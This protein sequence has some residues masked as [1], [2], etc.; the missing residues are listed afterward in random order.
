MRRHPIHSLEG[1]NVARY[2]W[3]VAARRWLWGIIATALL[4]GS[5]AVCAEENAQLILTL[6]AQPLAESLQQIAER[7]D[8]KIAFY[9]EFTDGLQAPA[10]IGTFTPS[11]A[12]D[13]L[14]ADTSLEYVYVVE[15]TVAVRPRT[16][17]LTER[18]MTMNEDQISN[19]HK[20]SLLRR[21]G[22]IFSGAMIATSGIAASD[23]KKEESEGVIDY[24]EEIVVTAE[25]REK[26]ILEVPITI[27]AFSRRMIDELGMTNEED[28]EQLVPGLQMLDD[29]GIAIRGLW[30][31]NMQAESGDPSV[32]VYVDGVYTVD[33]YGVA[34]NLFDVERIEVARGPQGTLHGRNSI[35]GAIFVHSKRPT[36]EFD[37]VFQGEF[38]DQF[39]QRYNFA[40]GG[41]ISDRF[42]Y[43]ITG[44][45]LS[46]DG[47]QENVGPAKDYGEPD[48]QDINT[49]LRFKT[50]RLDMNLSYKH[51]EDHGSPMAKIYLMD[52]P[53]DNRR[54]YTAW[55]LWEGEMPSTRNCPGSTLSK[56]DTVKPWGNGNED[57]IN[58]CDDPENIIFAN[59]DGIHESDSDRV[60]FTVDYDI[61]SAL[62]L[63]YTFG[64]GATD[65]FE[66]RDADGTGRVGDLEQ[67][68][69][70][71][72]PASVPL[73]DRPPVRDQS[74]ADFYESE[75]YSHE[76]VLSS[77]FD[78]P[79]NFVAGFYHY[80]NETAYNGSKRDETPQ[81]RYESFAPYDLIDGDAA[82]ASID[83]R[84]DGHWRNQ[85][86]DWQLSEDGE[87]IPGSWLP[88][89]A[90]GVENSDGEIIRPWNTTRFWG[91]FDIEP[92]A[93]PTSC[94]SMVDSMQRMYETSPG[95]WVYGNMLQT[96][97]GGAVTTHDRWNDTGQLF[98]SCDTDDFPYTQTY[99]GASD[100]KTTALFVH[101]DYELNDQWAVTAGLR[102][103]DDEKS[104][105]YGNRNLISVFGVPLVRGRLGSLIV[106]DQNDGAIWSASV[107]YTPA[108]TDTLIYGRVSNGQRLGG[109][110]GVGKDQFGEQETVGGK[111][112][113]EEL[114]NYELG[115]KGM[116]LD[117]QLMLT[118]AVFYNDYKTMHFM[119]WQLKPE[120]EIEPWDAQPYGAFMGNVDDNKI[121]GFEL[122]G[123][124][125]FADRWRLSGYYNYLDSEIG[126]HEAFINGAVRTETFQWT[127]LDFETGE[128]RSV[129]RG[130]P[131]DVTGNQLP[132]QPNHKLA[133]TLAYNMD[134]SLLGSDGNLQLL[135]TYSYTGDR[136]NNIGNV[137]GQ[138]IAAYSRLDLRANW[139]SSDGQW[140]ASLFV[141]N[142]LDD[143]GIREIN[144]RPVANTPSPTVLGTLSEPRRIGLLFR[145]QF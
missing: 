40:F 140:A 120:D 106:P 125:H 135:S 82:A 33:P 115:L 101:V 3:L 121:V 7:F 123:M 131:T 63:R 72:D 104:T 117:D 71:G 47:A 48:R 51:V 37:A 143:I 79:L 127:F 94:L 54:A 122:E 116:F 44:G 53:R 24:I 99:V 76:L 124:Y 83:G 60:A 91:D 81:L 8:L 109:S 26:N 14:L 138:E 34:P 141:Q 114:I 103:S 112:T 70:A 2:G 65:T 128:E 130:V 43:R 31:K 88:H 23:E 5:A 110:R 11:Q 74:W 75:E 113:N 85:D 38:T 42:S 67:P 129:E 132:Q 80:D 1:G 15:T 84:R 57:R 144:L 96:D 78:G 118:S 86:Y 107:E 50:D 6:P 137:P 52:L 55:Y 27:T 12:F 87:N 22:A 25:K 58:I 105:T 108:G 89:P 35:G 145:R 73:T 139:H 64:S 66:Q 13:A 45:H 102:S 77:A 10:L 20:P 61:S 119:S 69:R 29:D 39:T 4:T 18:G 111:L 126:P 90:Y 36:D 142:A 59:I 136:W 46:G 41:P 98:I 97:G 30:T 68:W 62:N 100:T 19:V 95:S 92:L 32:A 56:V 9:S 17:N 21:M 93:A 28:L 134:L 133:L 49:Q 16:T